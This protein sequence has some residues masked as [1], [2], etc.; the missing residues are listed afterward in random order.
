MRSE[1][2]CATEVIAQAIVL[3]GAV[4]TE[5]IRKGHKRN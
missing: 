4:L 3:D 1:G 5:A 2:L